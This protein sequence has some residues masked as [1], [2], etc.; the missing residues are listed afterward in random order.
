MT[1]SKLLSRAAILE[2]ADVQQEDVD[3]PE[4]GGVV[5]VRG[6][7]ARE[8]DA[9]EGTVVQA[10]GNRITRNTANISARLL[11]LT[12]IDEDGNLLFTQD[13]AEAL[14]NKS[15]EAMTRVTRVILRLSG[16]AP[17]SL[18]EATENLDGGQ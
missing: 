11:C 14:G 17:D 16:M 18:E 10:Q 8:R 4:W 2:V 15:G 1:E 13:D 3:V 12:A 7:T 6:L 9:F 5:R